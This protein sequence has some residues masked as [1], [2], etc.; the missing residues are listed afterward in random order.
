[1]A[2]AA[3]RDRGPARRGCR[4]TGS[5]RSAGQGARRVVAL[6]LRRHTGGAAVTT[7]ERNALRETVRRFAE[8]AVLPHLGD[9]E[10]AGEL[11]RDLHR[12]AGALG[13]LGVAFPEHAGGGGGELADAI[14]VVEEFHYAGGSGGL[15][16]GLLT[17]G[18]ALPHIVAAGDTE[19][20]DRWVRPTLAGEL[21][22]APAS[23]QTH[24]GAGAART[25]TTD[26]P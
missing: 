4:V 8:T 15:I 9:W 26:Q 6:P 22:G 24:G 7:P 10:R 12:K 18:I 21:I 20:I 1:P 17:C 23:T 16:A 5:V 13:L 2:R 11:P 19:Q 14:A 3:L 25:P